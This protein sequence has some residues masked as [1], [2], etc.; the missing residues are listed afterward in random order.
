M[1]FRIPWQVHSVF[2]CE[3]TSCGFDHLVGDGGAVREQ[4]ADAV[5]TKGSDQADVEGDRV[6]GDKP[7]AEVRETHE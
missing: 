1:P 5:E 4:L 2:N 3:S 7:V 6:H